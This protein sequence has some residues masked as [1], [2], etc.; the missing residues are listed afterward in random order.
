[1]KKY[2]VIEHWVDAIVG[3]ILWH[4]CGKRLENILREAGDKSCE[5]CPKGSDGFRHGE[6]MH[7]AANI[8]YRFFH[9]IN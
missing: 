9:L 6:S 1:M 2:K 8:V 3:F 5:N 7:Y 4:I